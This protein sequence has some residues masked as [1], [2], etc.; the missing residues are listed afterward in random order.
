MD[1]RKSL[2]ILGG[3]VVG[4][5]GLAL[6]NWKWQITDQLTHQGFFSYQEEKLISSIADTII[7]EGLPPQLPNPDAKPIGALST[8]TDSY[9]KKLFEHCYDQD[10]QAD[11]KNGLDQLNQQANLEFGDDFYNLPKTER[12]ASLMQMAN[13]E[14]EK[15]KEF[16]KLM[17]S[18]TITG[19]TTVKEVMVD[20]QGY[21]VAPGFYNGCA[22]VKSKA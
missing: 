3:S 13:S 14:D 8:G 22:E 9:L 21:Q 4:I 11:I 2:K 20:Y 1:R 5:A 17:K 19:F 18:Q 12:E 6:V 15:Q 16:F 10:D 7:P